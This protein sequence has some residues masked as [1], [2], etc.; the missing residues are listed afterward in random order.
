MAGHTIVDMAQP[1]RP[2]DEQTKVTF[3]LP[4]RL[5]KRAK[6]Y[7]IDTDQDLQDVV[8]LALERFLSA[9]KAR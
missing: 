1:T 4:D 6:H 8:R 9:E 3:R 2:A 5:V 7:A